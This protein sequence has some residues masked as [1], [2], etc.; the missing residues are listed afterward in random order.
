MNDD[1]RNKDIKYDEINN[2]NQEKLP[3]DLTPKKVKVL[4]MCTFVFFLSACFFL[5]FYITTTIS[6]SNK[7]N[8]NKDNNVASTKSEALDEEIKIILEEGNEKSVYTLAQFKTQESLDKEYSLT[9]ENLTSMLRNQGFQLTDESKSQIIFTKEY[10]SGKYYIGF[11]DG[12]LAI[13]QADTSQKIKIVKTYK[14]D[15]HKESLIEQEV[16]NNIRDNKEVFDTIDDADLR[17]S[18]FSS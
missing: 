14:D 16:K 11:S 6:N 7:T 17:I 8:T 13:F 1:F 15:R 9:K 10:V 5:S 4:R 2:E 12:Y 3:G 18:E